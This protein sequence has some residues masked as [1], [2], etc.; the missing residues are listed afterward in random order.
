MALMP[1][2]VGEWVFLIRM[3]LGIVPQVLGMD[4]RNKA[5]EELSLHSWY[6]RGVSAPEYMRMKKGE[7][8]CDKADMKTN[9]VDHWPAN[10]CMHD[11][12][13]CRD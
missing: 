9:K 13:A 1:L 11:R 7:T 5:L 3:S 6:S 4:H 10:L 2:S 8:T 12:G